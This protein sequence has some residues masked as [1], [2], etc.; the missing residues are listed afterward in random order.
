[1]TVVKREAFLHEK[2]CAK[3]AKA[4]SAAAEAGQAVTAG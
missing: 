4:G 2:G 1:L 3:K